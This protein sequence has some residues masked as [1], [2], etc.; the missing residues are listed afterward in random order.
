PRNRSTAAQVSSRMSNAWKLFRTSRLSLQSFWSV[1]RE[2][3]DRAR[4]VLPRL[5]FKPLPELIGVEDVVSSEESLQDSAAAGAPHRL[6]DPGTRPAAR[7]LIGV[8]RIRRGA[9]D[10][11]VH[12]EEKAGVA[13]RRRIVERRQLVR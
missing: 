3:R 11:Q 5:R 4:Y 9:Q 6:L 7:T 10:R 13:Q 8:E 1:S 2:C 12:V